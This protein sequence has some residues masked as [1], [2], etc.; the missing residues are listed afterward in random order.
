M[1]SKGP[2]I[3][4]RDARPINFGTVHVVAQLLNFTTPAIDIG[5]QHIRLLR[6]SITLL[7]PSLPLRWNI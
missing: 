4:T 1:S 6:A 7:L 5:H 2:R 3:A